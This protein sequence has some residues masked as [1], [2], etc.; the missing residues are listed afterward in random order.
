VEALQNEKVTIESENT[1]LKEQIE[2]STDELNDL[3]E[4]YTNLGIITRR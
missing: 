3:R 4:Q 2:L 1:D